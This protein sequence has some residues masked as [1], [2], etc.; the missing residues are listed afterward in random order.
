MSNQLKTRNGIP[1]DFVDGLRIKGVDVTNWDKVFIDQGASYVGFQ[2]VGNL[3]ASNVQA[4]IAELESQKQSKSEPITTAINLRPGANQ[5]VVWDIDA[6]GGGGDSASITLE[7]A[8]GE[9]TKM[10]FKM[11]NDADD[12]FEFTAKTPDGLT[13]FN[14]AMSLNG[15]VLLNAANYVDYAAPMITDYV[16]L[17]TY[18]GNA[19]QVRIASNGIAG[20]FYRD[21][22]DTT[23]ADNGGTIIVS[24]NGKRWKRLYDSAVNVKWFGAKGDWNGTTGTDDTIPIQATINSGAKSIYIPPGSFLISAPINIPVSSTAICISGAGKQQ[25]ILQATG[26][27]NAVINIGNNTAQMI[28]GRYEK[29]GIRAT[30][31]TVN[32]GIYGSRVEEHTF[33]ALWVS[34]CQIAAVSTGYGYVNNFI[35]CEL[36]YNVG[37][38]FRTNTDYL[39]GANNALYFSG[40]LLFS[41]SGWGLYAAGGYGVWLEGCTIEANSKGGIYLRNVSGFR[42]NG[43]FEDNGATGFTVTSPAKTIRS[44][45]VINGAANDTT[46]SSAFPCNSGVIEGCILQASTGKTS[47]IYNGGAAGLSIKNCGTNNADTTPLYAEQ[48]DQQY[49]GTVVSIEN[50]GTYRNPII[51]ENATPSTNNEAA[52]LINLMGPA[53]LSYGRL[54]Y[55]EQNLALQDFNQWSLQVGGTAS[56][57]RRRISDVTA[58]FGDKPVWEIRSTVAGSSDRYGFS[59]DA[60]L[61]ANEMSGKLFWYGAWVYTTDPD[62]YP[63][64]HS[65]QQTFNNNPPTTG[66][67]QFKAVSFTW[68]ATGIMTFGVYK[69]GSST[70]TVYISAPI[71]APVGVNLN[72]AMGTIMTTRQWLGTS[73][74]TQ[75]AWKQGDKIVNSQP[76]A[77]GTPEWVCIESG[78]P[79]VWKATP[80]LLA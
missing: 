47:F 62:C 38:G 53:N 3:A 29:F 59:I 22:A 28:R 18:A 25:T 75:G 14:N 41:N 39:S 5:G 60:A 64:L 11:T 77:L 16:E 63:V 43:Y 71:I 33:I 7:T 50:C 23:S 12:N 55:S 15:N 67:W 51:I 52:A 9:A 58:L 69:S 27:F 8:G 49:K 37:D 42:I 74:P 72:R 66:S 10:R 19:A 54:A 61:L 2:P 20:F 6:F 13:V 35:D 1:F 78:I 32:Y 73:T 68:P 36:S 45:I 24:S 17:R 26:T 76:V 31:A 30:G 57:W 21:D 34:G 70:G 4:A 46:L 48:Y 65:S 79:G 80:G 56:I 40:C 44:D